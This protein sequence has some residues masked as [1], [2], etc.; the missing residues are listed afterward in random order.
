MK[1]EVLLFT[2]GVDSFIARE[3]LIDSGHDIDCLYFN[4]GGR[5]TNHEVEKIKSLL[6]P[7]IIDTRLN[8]G[9][10][11]EDDAHIPNRNILFTTLALSLGYKKVWLGGS[12]SDRVGDNKSEVYQRYS[13]LLTT[14]NEEY[15][16]IDSP[17]YDCY[18]DDMV[19]WYTRRHPA[20]RIDL[21]KDT[22][23]CFNPLDEEKER[24]VYVQGLK[25]RYVTKECM[26]CPAC[27]RKSA[28]LYSGDIFTMHENKK[29]VDHYE[30]QFEKP[31][32]QTSRTV[33]TMQYIGRW[34]EELDA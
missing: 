22:F 33:G 32:I 11:E 25:G 5:Y 28:V 7:V 6:Y 2:S 31:L 21:L 8:L 13:E 18:K 9:D 4:H 23:S 29:N 10:I 1:K 34:Y 27:F 15:C 17:F 24:D 12:L 19:R 3:F 26:N 16:R 30:R 14:V 20:S